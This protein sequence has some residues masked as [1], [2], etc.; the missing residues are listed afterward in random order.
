[1]F[2]LL[3]KY[4]VKCRLATVSY[5]ITVQVNVNSNTRSTIYNIE[6][7]SSKSNLDPYIYPD[8]LENTFLSISLVNCNF[9]SITIDCIQLYSLW[10]YF[11]F[12]SHALKNHSQTWAQFHKHCGYHITPHTPPSTPPH[13]LTV[14]HAS[15]S[16][17]STWQDGRLPKA[18]LDLL[19]TIIE[20]GLNSCRS[21]CY[22]VVMR[23]SETLNAV[24]D[25]TV[26]QRD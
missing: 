13:P 15:H 6:R 18:T 5:H 8:S 9:L 23:W 25:V 7:N 1:M 26:V 17:T 12:R 19:H 3:T 2:I 20:K 22:Y 4:F 14:K 11:S 24:S 10:Y 21:R 16:S